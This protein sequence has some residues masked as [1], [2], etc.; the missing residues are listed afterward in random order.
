[1]PE[2]KYSRSYLDVA[3]V[4]MATPGLGEAAVHQL[5]RRLTVNELLSNTDM[6]LKNIGLI[7]LDGVTPQLS[8]A[9]DI[10]AY[11]AYSKRIG[12]ALHILPPDTGAKPRLR[13]Q[14]AHAAKAAKP[15]LSPIVLRQFCDRLGILERPAAAVVRDT[16]QR[17]VKAWPPMI[18]NAVLTDR[19]KAMMFELFDANPLVVSARKRIKV[20]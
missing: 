11:G 8:L 15:G 6:H 13:A 10:V 3:A 20:A 18:A 16:V 19:Q 2:D 14:P 17:A 12:H 1:M 9:Y 7:Y 5:L 4:M